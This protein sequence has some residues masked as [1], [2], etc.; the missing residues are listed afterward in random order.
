MEDNVD[1]CNSGSLHFPCNP[2]NTG[3]VVCTNCYK[4][5]NKLKEVFSELSSAKLIIKL[6]QEESQKLDCLLPS[7]VVYRSR[8]HSSASFNITKLSIGGLSSMADHQG[9]EVASPQIFESLLSIKK[10]NIC[11]CCEIMKSEFHEMKLELSSCKEIIRILLEEIRE[12]RPPEQ[13]QQRA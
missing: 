6:L 7:N 13:R 11:E 8:H 12:N 5:K 4:F 3:V 10:V 9:C 1:V 2:S